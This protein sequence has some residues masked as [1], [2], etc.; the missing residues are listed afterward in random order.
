MMQ[1]AVTVLLFASETTRHG[2]TRSSFMR[3][4]YTGRITLHDI[5]YIICILSE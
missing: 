4:K 5:V 2:R 1:C 3:F